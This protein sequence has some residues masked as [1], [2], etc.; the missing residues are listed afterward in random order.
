[1]HLRYLCFTLFVAI[2]NLVVANTKIDSLMGQLSLLE[3]Q[4]PSLSLAQ[5]R[6]DLGEQYRN[7]GKFEKALIEFT[8]GFEYAKTLNNLSLMTDCM[9]GLAKSHQRLT[10]FEKALEY[11]TTLVTNYDHVIEMEQKGFIYSQISDIYQNLGENQKAYEIQMQALQISEE[12]AD[13]N[14]IAR[15]NYSLASIFYYQQQYDEALS[16]YENAYRLGQLV[17]NG[18]LIYSCLAAIG[19]VYEKKGDMEQSL[20]YN[21]RSLQMATEISYSFGV[22]YAY[23]N[24][25]A[26]YWLLGEFKKAENYYLKSLQM[27]EE[28]GD[29]W[30]AIGGNYGLGD[31]YI[32]WGFPDQAIAIISVGLELS[33]SI[34]SKPR[35]LEG[36][37]LL[38]DAYTKKN[39]KD[40]AFEYL[41]KYVSLKD[42]IINEKTVEEMGQSKRRYEIQKREQEIKLLKA[43]N[44]L[45]EKNQKIQ[46]LR[47]YSFGFAILLLLVASG[48]FFSRNK[49]HQKMNNLLEEKNAML[50]HKNDEI[51]IKNEQLAESNENLSQFAYVAS[52][53]LKE[54]LRMINSYTRL[55][56]RRYTGLFDENA[57]EFMFY[58]TDAVGRM[59][60]LLD[61]LLDFS[62]AGNNK[63]VSELL[64]FNDIMFIVKSNL[65]VQLGELN[66]TLVAEEKDI[67]AINVNRT[68]LIQL[69]QNLVS[70]GVKFRGERD[71]VVTVD[72]VPKD[73]M[74]L[75]SIADNGIGISDENKPKVFE[76]FRRLHTREEYAG[77]GI[78]LATCKR[79]I[80][81]YGGDIWVES[82]LGEGSTFFFTLPAGTEEPVLA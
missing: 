56:E 64:N 72:C 53:D 69:I 52:H 5:T 38:S 71:P 3:K 49:L 11:Y 23:G 48:W 65:Q 74:M 35:L 29:K 12:I 19:S 27:K 63:V 51:H 31:T 18:R 47:N 6:H 42:S 75:F 7:D 68:Q 1:M 21:Q 81:H 77:T 82:T 33:K 37:K 10:R 45:F 61:D 40:L 34:D 60:T 2:A 9:L 76:M 22:A 43:D 39:D 26:N 16:Y 44:E 14:G 57:K 36:Y 41:S 8:T 80:D 25:G 30:G 28:L 20:H 66:A 17:D 55:L 62:R 13:T 15:S 46:N 70:N 67:P 4:R 59:T 54:P 32:S 24:L 79:I 58:I 73:G 50:N 78:G